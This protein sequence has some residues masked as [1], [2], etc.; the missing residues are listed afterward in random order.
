M[1]SETVLSN[2]R[3]I[4]H[5]AFRKKGTDNCSNGSAPLNNMAAMPMYGKNT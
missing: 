3:K 1:Y 4:L 5:G 2:F